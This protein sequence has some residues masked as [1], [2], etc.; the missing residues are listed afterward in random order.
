MGKIAMSRFGK[1]DL[2]RGIEGGVAT[3]GT[4]IGF[5]EVN[6]LTQLHELFLDV[7]MH[8]KHKKL[9]WIDQVCY[10]RRFYR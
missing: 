7:K 1:E 9:C 4:F 10:C 6:R 8:L 2:M 5:T 3:I